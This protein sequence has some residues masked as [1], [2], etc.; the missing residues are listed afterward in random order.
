MTE[1]VW[2]TA[3][4]A[5]K[6]IGRG[7]ETL[8]VD[9]LKKALLASP[10]V[11]NHEQLAVFATEGEKVA[12]WMWF[13]YGYFADEKKL[14][15][16]ASAQNHWTSEEFRGRGIGTGLVKET[17][18]LPMYSVFS[19]PS[20]Q[21]LPIHRKLGINFLDEW[22]IYRIPLLWA[23]KLRNWRAQIYDEKSQRTPVQAYI[24]VERSRAQ[25]LRGVRQGWE[26][27]A[28][29]DVC[30][31]VAVLAKLRQKRFQ[32]PWNCEAI[33]RAARCENDGMRTYLF[34][35]PD[36]K[37][38]FVSVYLREECVRLPLTQKCVRLKEGHVNEIFP[39]IES[40]SDAAAI[41]AILGRRSLEEGVDSLALYGSTSAIIAAMDRAGVP[42]I[43]A[44]MVA[45]IP[46]RAEDAGTDAAS[47]AKNWWCRVL[48]EEQVE[49]TGRKGEQLVF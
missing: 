13:T 47:L 14:V 5:K 46:P 31:G 27:L 24:D 4:E 43:G 18:K 26:A 7:D 17:L 1:Y 30:D 20:G 19:G 10:N 35:N 32:F 34:R 41:V 11:E 38:F 16:I 44:R 36:G 39:P 45:I 33:W 8:P 25:V 6:R 48:N 12:G 49:E 23:G 15:R 2:V 9:L 22:P 21:G 40:E 28:A 29:D 3:D 37:K 42:R